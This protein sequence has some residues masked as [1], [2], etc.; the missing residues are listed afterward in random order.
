MENKQVGAK[1]MCTIEKPK[2]TNFSSTREGDLA[3]REGKDEG[4]SGQG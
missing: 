3:F 1:R 4:E 2:L